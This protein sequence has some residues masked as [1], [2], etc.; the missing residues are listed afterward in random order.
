MKILF[1][2]LSIDLM[3]W[4]PMLL[5]LLGAFILGWLLRYFLSEKPKVTALTDE[6]D[7]LQLS[8]DNYKREAEQK[9]S[10]LKLRHDAAAIDAAKL[11][12]ALVKI[13][14]LNA[15]LAFAEKKIASLG[16][17]KAPK[18]DF[19]AASK[20]YGAKIVADDLKLVE[21]IGPKI[22]QVFH[23]AGLKTWLSVAESTPER[24]K[25][26]LHAAG[27]QFS[28]HDPATW[29][30]QCRM[31]YDGQWAELKK[32]QDELIAGREE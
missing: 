27:N 7:N 22:E 16:G 26:I 32:W 6:R 3:C 19:A 18:Q 29:P 1:I 13:D 5:W 11:A 20:I 28:M 9:Y 4:L 2:L 17:D 15:A 12:P 24:L 23:E 31:M 25:E 8:F 10:D 30:H 14:E 21:G